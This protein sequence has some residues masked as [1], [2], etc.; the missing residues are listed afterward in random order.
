[1]ALKNNFK[2]IEEEINS[3]SSLLSSSAEIEPKGFKSLV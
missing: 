1:L 3:V 2:L